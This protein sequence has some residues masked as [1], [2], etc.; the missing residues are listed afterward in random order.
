MSTFWF[1]VT[2]RLHAFGLGSCLCV[3]V[4]WCLSFFLFFYEYVLF[5]CVFHSL[6]LSLLGGTNCSSFSFSFLGG[7]EIILEPSKNAM[8]L[9][10]RFPLFFSHRSPP[11]D[12]IM[13]TAHDDGEPEV[14]RG[15]DRRT[16]G[17]D[18]PPAPPLLD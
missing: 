13:W 1:P 16:D 4:V 18:H 6:S 17:G 9:G 7:L 10:T 14:V 5:V 8:L 12:K 11:F 2:G 15:E 3:S